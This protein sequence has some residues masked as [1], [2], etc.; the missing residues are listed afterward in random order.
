MMYVSKLPAEQAVGVKFE[1]I[2]WTTPKE[3][4]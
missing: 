2:G 1:F 3:V 4:T